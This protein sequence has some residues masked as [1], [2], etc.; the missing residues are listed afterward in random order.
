MPV[1]ILILHFQSDP[2]LEKHD[3]SRRIFVSIYSEFSNI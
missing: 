3:L 1:F 2:K